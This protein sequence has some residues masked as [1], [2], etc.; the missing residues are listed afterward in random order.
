MV[1]PS[2]LRSINIQLD[3]EYPHRVAHFRPTT[4]SVGLISLAMRKQGGRAV[5]VVAPYGSGKSIA[6]AYL[7]HL[8]ENRFEAAETL[9]RVEGRLSGIEANLAE[10]SRRRRAGS[11]KGLFVPLYGHLSSTPRAL[12]EAVLNAMR[13]VKLGR[14]ARTVDGLRVEETRDVRTLLRVCTEKMVQSGQDRIVI[15]WDEFGRHLQGLVS[16]GRPEELDVIQVL[17]EIAS[18]SS[19]V[20]ISLVLLL[21]RSLLGY[22]TGLPAGL[23]REWAKIEGRFETLQYLDDSAELYELIGSLVRESRSRAPA[24][25]DFDQLATESKSVGLFPHLGVERVASVLESAYPLAP[26]TLHLLPRVAA[27][28]A[29]NE[30]TIFSFLQWAPLDAPVLPSAVYEYFRSDFRTDGGAGGTQ[31]AWL[32]AESALGKV[33]ADSLKEEA[34]K[35]AF[36]LS[37]GLSGERGRATYGQ[38]AFA[39]GVKTGKKA[40]ETLQDLIRQHL[41]IHRHHSDQVVVWHGTDVDLRGR[42]L[43]ERDRGAND[44]V[45]PPFLSRE[46]PP[47]VWRPVEYNA[48]FGIRRY[49]EAEYTTVDGLASF[50]DELELAGGW[51]PGTDGHVLYVLPDTEEELAEAAQLA[52]ENRDPRLFIVIAPEVASLRDAALDLWCL[53]RM[54]TDAELLATDPLVGVELDHLTDDARTGLRPLVDRV[55]RPQPQGSTWFY[56]GQEVAVRSMSE[57]RRFLSRA[58]E[59]VF[60]LTPEIHSEMVVRRRPSPVLVNARKKVELGLLERFGREDVGIEGNFADKAIFRCVF[61][62]TGLYRQDGNAWRL[63]NPEELD[64]QGLRS[65]WVRIKN[66][67]TDPGRD[68]SI[69]RLLDELREPPYGVRDG[70]FPLLIAAGFKAFPSAATLRQRGRFVDDLLPSVIEDMVRSPADYALDVMGLSVEQETYLRGILKLFAGSGQAGGERDLFRAC[71]SAVLAWRHTL[72]A[73]AGSSRRISENARAFEREI[74]TLDPVGLFM[75]VLP[76]LAR[77]PTNEPYHLVEG[78]RRLKDELDGVTGVFRNEAVEALAQALAARGIDTSRNGSNGASVRTQASVWASCF[79]KSITSHLPDHVTKGVLGRLRFNYRSDETLVNALSSLLVG[80]PLQEWDD[81]VVP[82]FRRQL[83][84]ALDVIESTAI[85]LSRTSGVNSELKE[86]LGRLTEAR[87]R[88]V[89]IQLAEL[90]GRES[91]ANQLEAIASDLRNGSPLQLGVS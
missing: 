23:R 2:F 13:R 37:L 45:M 33:P 53:L 38:L 71:M 10:L 12:K 14:Q 48:R 90:V 78:A 28:V 50:L 64:G 29:Q 39:L 40:S 18:R 84:Q 47:P 41:L 1:E 51:K 91:A 49:C 20:P 19:A 3:V 65:V 68:K 4:K 30:R 27:R 76:R 86:G 15:V 21:H 73:A 34:L 88:T 77:T 26:A 59:A 25:T 66:F 35:T 6:S 69:Q 89:A 55:V 79:P 5:F 60:P 52:R 17:A 80:L 42:L 46:I 87:T 9:Q 7:G 82:S 22:A 56:M 32:E 36:L 57:L 24:E 8:V 74:S 44:F 58:M 70:L 63:A 67:F 11:Q 62:R 31:R 72:P 43:D 16:E 54:Q 81:A 85:R 61:L 75:E 83:R